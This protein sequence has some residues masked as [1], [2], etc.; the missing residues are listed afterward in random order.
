MLRVRHVSNMSVIQ[1]E[2]PN[3]PQDRIG[4]S[5]VLSYYFKNVG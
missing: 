4:V 1:Y 3:L 2:R 5:N